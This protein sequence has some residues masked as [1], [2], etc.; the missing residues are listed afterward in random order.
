MSRFQKPTRQPKRPRP[1][2]VRLSE[3][4]LKLLHNACEPHESL[5]ECIRRLAIGSLF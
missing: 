4:D 2:S 1:V 3:A 5:S